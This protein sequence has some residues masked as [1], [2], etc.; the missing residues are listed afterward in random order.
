MCRGG[1]GS[2]EEITE[3]RPEQNTHR[4]TD[5]WQGGTVKS[6]LDNP[7]YTSYAIFGRWT[8]HET[9]LDSDDVA[10]GHVVRFRKA[11]PDRIVRSRRPA[12][13]EIVSVEEF[14]QVQLLRKSR[15]AGGMRGRA[16]LERTRIRGTR[17][18][19][20]RGLM[21]CDVRSKPGCGG[22]VMGHAELMTSA[23]PSSRASHP[24]LRSTLAKGYEGWIRPE[25]RTGRFVLPASLSVQMLVKIEDSVLRPPEFVNGV[26][27]THS[28]IEGGCAPR[29]LQVELSPLGAY[30]VFGVPADL[31]AGRL[32]DLRD[33]LGGDSR[34][35][36][37]RLRDLPTWTQ[38]FDLLDQFLLARLE[39]APAVSPEVRFAWRRLTETSGTV[40]I[41]AICREIGWSHRHLISRFRQ[42][43]GLTP[44]RAARVSRFEHLRRRLAREQSRPDCDQLAATTGYADQAHMIRDFRQFFGSTPAAYVREQQGQSAQG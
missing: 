27:D 10:A 22:E 26:L 25:D 33:L 40:Q 41:A 24:A 28:T 34:R 5:G 19:V 23:P 21:R 29:Y 7:R 2:L 42:Q 35:L 43:V 8:K 16:K 32:I 14:T 44:K 30:Q 6:I 13:P 39:A 20:F 37:E 4:L 1:F 38:R 11:A 12:H 15:A 17:P 3:R 9:L 18:Y 36:G 31:L